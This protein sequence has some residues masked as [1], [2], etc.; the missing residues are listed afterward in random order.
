M[1]QTKTTPVSR[2]IQKVARISNEAAELMRTLPEEVA[3]ALIQGVPSPRLLAIGVLAATK[4]SPVPV[5]SMRFHI[6]ES[7]VIMQRD[8]CLNAMRIIPEGSGRYV[9][10]P[11]P[12]EK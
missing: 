10:P 6:P 11:E 7:W 4:R 5:L 3:L 1:P 8:A 12:I 9:P 2:A